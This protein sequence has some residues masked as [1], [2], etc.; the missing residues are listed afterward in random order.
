VEA[1]LLGFIWRLAEHNEEKA[2]VIAQNMSLLQLF[3]LK[4]QWF[5][6]GGYSNTP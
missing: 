3:K 2:L 6:S 5:R 1:Y 4:G